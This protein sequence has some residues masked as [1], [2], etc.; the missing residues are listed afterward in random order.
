MKKKTIK[1]IVPAY[2]MTHTT[3]QCEGCGA[4]LEFEGS[5]RE[6]EICGKEVCPNCRKICYIAKNVLYFDLSSKSFILVNDYHD[7]GEAVKLCEDCYNKIKVNEKDYAAK[8]Q[9][10]VND[11]NKNLEQLSNMYLKGECK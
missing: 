9:E 6:C 11:F 4:E 7:D 3:Y 5:I 10:L 8:I 2:E 1:K